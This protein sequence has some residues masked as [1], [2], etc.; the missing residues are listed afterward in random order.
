MATLVSDDGAYGGPV[1]VAA[2]QCAELRSRGHDAALLSLWR[3][4]GPPPADVDGVPLLA[5]PARTVLPGMGFLA[6]LN[7]RLLRLLWRE[8][9]RADVMHLHAGR[10]LVTLAALA[11]ARLRRTPFLVQ[12]HGMVPP[13]TKPVARLFDSVYVP[14]LRRARACLVLTEEEERGLATVFHG[15]HPPLLRL[16]N[17]VRPRP[18][19]GEPDGKLVLYLARLHPRKRPEAFVAAAGLLL[20]RLPGLRFVLHGADEGSLPEVERAIAAQRL[21]SWVEYR[22]PVPHGTALERLA[23]AAVYVL[24]SVHEPFP[25]SVLEALAAGTPVV[26]TSSCGIAAELASTGAAL[27]TDGTPQALADA[28]ERLLTD[29]GLR[30]RTV[31]AGRAAVAGVFSLS[32]VADRLA[33][34]Y[35]EAL[36]R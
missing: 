29:D 30:E 13:R 32:A 5:V 22:G 12:T 24:P 19:T 2:G 4:A 26:A 34:L 20:P 31:A 3:G 21:E 35:T 11:V 1:S 7:P 8:T 18:R 25:M 10:D 16:A 14:L 15:R 36:R 28:V 23:E 17:G 9:G 33:A 27:I 6:L